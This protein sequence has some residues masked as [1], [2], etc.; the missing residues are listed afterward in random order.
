MLLDHIHV[1]T[2]HACIYQALTIHLPKTQSLVVAT[3]LS[4]LTKSNM[5]SFQNHSVATALLAFL[6]LLYYHCPSVAT[7]LPQHCCHWV[8]TVDFCRHCVATALSPL[9]CHCRFLSPLLLPLLI[10]SNMVSFQYHGV[11]TGIATVLPLYFLQ[12]H[13]CDTT[14]TTQW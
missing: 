7:V 3:V 10:K 5:A 11:V 4:L 6:S 1:S 9:C 2:N 8:V 13:H 14:V 12:W